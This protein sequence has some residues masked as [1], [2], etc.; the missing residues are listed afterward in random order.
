MQLPDVKREQ[1]LTNVSH[2]VQRTAVLKKLQPHG[3]TRSFGW[4]VSHVI[5]CQERVVE[6]TALSVVC[7]KYYFAIL[8]YTEIL[9]IVL[10]VDNNYNYVEKQN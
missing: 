4:S 1:C 3:A 2:L 5:D 6:Y 9:Y 10:F 8:I 7:K